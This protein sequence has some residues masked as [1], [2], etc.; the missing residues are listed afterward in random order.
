MTFHSVWAHLIYV[1]PISL[2]IDDFIEESLL[3]PASNT[4]RRRVERSPADALLRM[5]G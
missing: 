1:Y 2:V 5:S 4:V 3:S